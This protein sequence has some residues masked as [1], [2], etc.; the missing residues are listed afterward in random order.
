MSKE[1][2]DNIKEFEDNINIKVSQIIEIAII[3]FLIKY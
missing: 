3:D 2:S 1:L